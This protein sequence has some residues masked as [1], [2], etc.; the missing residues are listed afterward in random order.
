MKTQKERQQELDSLK[1]S[2]TALITNEM[3]KEQI[4]NINNIANQVD[5]VNN[6]MDELQ[7][8]NI[9]LKD[10]LIA[11]IRGTA[12]N[13]SEDEEQQPPTFEEILA[14]TIAKRK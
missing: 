13:K 7:K 2:I 9:E 11:S 14:Q 6:S 8:E 3:S 12:S 4:E 1:K 10:S 5:G